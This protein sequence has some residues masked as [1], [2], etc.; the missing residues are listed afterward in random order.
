ME[1]WVVKVKGRDCYYAV[2]R[3]LGFTSCSR[4][5]NPGVYDVQVFASKDVAQRALAAIP[6]INKEDDTWEVVPWDE[7]VIVRE[8]R[9]K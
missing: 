1:K 3:Y 9:T 7:G 6:E 8:D 5:G 2:Q 4:K